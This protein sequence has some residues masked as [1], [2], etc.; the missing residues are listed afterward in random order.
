MANEV[1]L[2]FTQ[3]HIAIDNKKIELQTIAA[4]AII[5]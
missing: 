3:N 1:T 5:S 4:A 2:F